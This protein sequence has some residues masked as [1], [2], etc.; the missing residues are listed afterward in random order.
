MPAF[1]FIYSLMVKGRFSNLALGFLGNS[2]L[3]VLSA[4]N[5]ERVLAGSALAA[6]YAGYRQ[7]TGMFFP[8]LGR[9]SPGG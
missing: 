4:R 5:D 7:R 1:H 9:N 6:D 2:T 3:I 8:R